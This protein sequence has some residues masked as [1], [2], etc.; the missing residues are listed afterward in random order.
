M[1]IYQIYTTAM[2]Q[3]AYYFDETNSKHRTN[4]ALIFHYVL[5]L[6]SINSF[7]PIRWIAQDPQSKCST[8]ESPKAKASVVCQ[9]GMAETPK[10]TQLCNVCGHYVTMAGQCQWYNQET[11]PT[12]TVAAKSRKGWKASK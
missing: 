4:S 6:A 7:L 12:F 1:I 5:C 9:R 10:K 8:C 2:Y 11:L 3:N